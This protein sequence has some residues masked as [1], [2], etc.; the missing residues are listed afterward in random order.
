[1]VWS[2]LR[3]F[4]GFVLLTKASDW[5]VE[6]AASLARKFGIQPYVIGATLVAV[7]T[8]LPEVFTTVYA[9]W[10]GKVDIALA[11][12]IGSNLANVGLC[13][14]LA[15][16]LAPL[17]LDRDVFAHDAP[18]F[19]LAAA[20]LFILGADGKLGRFDG[21][22]LLSFLVIFTLALLSNKE[23][24][25]ALD[26]PECNVSVLPNKAISWR[27]MAGV[28]GFAFGAQWLV[29]GA[30]DVA[31]TFG[32]QEW[33]IGLTV[34]A[35]GT[36]LPEMATS[37]AAAYRGHSG[38]A[39]GNVMGSNVMNIY[40]VLG[41]AAVLTPVPVS[42]MA[43]SFDIPTLFGVSFIF[44]MMLHGRRAKR[45]FGV[46]MVLTYIAVLW[47]TLCLRPMGG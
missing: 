18:H 4:F 43:V 37:V 30:T 19:L 23:P 21:V 26:D 44:V 13:F 38:I 36:S 41:L 33:I 22:V 1:M 27:I 6:G 12:V 25:E 34:V 11:N 15:V 24:G 7:G 42:E 40:L 46:M 20:M 16:A 31:R 47:T 14:G 10:T 45:E 35:F 2:V 29:E 28:V 39:V 8:S 3:I 5:F 32:I 9:A 17:V